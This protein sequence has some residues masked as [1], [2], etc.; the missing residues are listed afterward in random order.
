MSGVRRSDGLLSAGTTLGTIQFVADQGARCE[1]EE[2]VRSIGALHSA[3]RAGIRNTLLV[4]EEL[5]LV[6]ID[7][8]FVVLQEVT[9]RHLGNLSRLL[10]DTLFEGFL[11]TRFH[12][13]L[14]SAVQVDPEDQG[15]WVDTFRLP[16]RSSGRLFLLVEFGVLH[17]ETLTSR[18]WRL[19]AVY[20]ERF[21]SYIRSSNLLQG[22]PT[23]KTLDALKAEL[24][25]K[26]EKG[27]IAE[28]WVVAF[29]R[30]RLDGHP[31]VEEVRRIS[32]GDV[33]AGYDIVSFSDRNVL[34][35]DR[36]IEVK[37]FEGSCRF[38][39]TENE[40]N[41]AREYK[42]NYCLYLVDRARFQEDGYV[43]TIIPGPYSYFMESG[44]AGWERLCD[45]YRFT[46]EDSG[47]N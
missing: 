13:R 47:L 37:S 20:A 6:R 23:P 39:W 31:F 12:P 16:G 5:D 18:H 45:V 42:E 17:R 27:R 1:R 41:K 22:S 7:D 24:D 25:A 36:F 40:R 14:S 38:Y 2:I 10:A 4:L 11:E 29:E 19:D 43:P 34:G 15:I 8:G 46:L 35:H 9:R 28:E 26:A 30:K 32:D 33:A 44:A 3:S 21:L